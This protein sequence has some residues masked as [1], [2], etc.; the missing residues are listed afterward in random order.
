MQM[1]EFVGQYYV[2]RRKYH[3]SYLAQQALAK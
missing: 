2:A 3:E 1:E